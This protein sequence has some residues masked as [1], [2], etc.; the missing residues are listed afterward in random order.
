MDEH[1]PQPLMLY[2]RYQP[3]NTRFVDSPPGSVLRGFLTVTIPATT[4]IARWLVRRR[5]R[6]VMTTPRRKRWLGGHANTPVG[7][8]SL[9]TTS[10]TR[11]A[12]GM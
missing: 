11:S 9:D 2:D 8:R 7:M 5:A 1:C 12:T 4:T 3:K 10:A 6:L